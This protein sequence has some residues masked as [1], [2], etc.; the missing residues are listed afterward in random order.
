[1][2]EIVD[3]VFLAIWGIWR[4]RWT[5]IIVAWIVCLLGWFAVGSLEE[6]YT[7]SARIYV[8]S[9]NI[10]A[11][12][13]KGIAVQPNVQQRV[14]L[15]SRALLTRPNLEKLMRMA[16]LGNE[17]TNE[18]EREAIL[19]KLKYSIKLNSG[20]RGESVYT[21]SYSNTDSEVAIRVVQSLIKI[22]IDGSVGD[23][24]QE[25]FDAREFLDKQIADYEV[26]LG[27]AETRLTDFKRLNTG[28]M[29]SDS[30]GY[31]Q[32]LELSISQQRSAAL[33]LKEA[34]NR[35]DEI[36]RQME[37]ERPRIL[38]NG[39]DGSS[40]RQ[41]RIRGLQDQLDELLVRYTDRHPR[42]AQLRET[43]KELRFD[44]SQDRSSTTSANQ[45]RDL[46]SSVVYQTM[47]TMLVEAEA[48]LAELQV[49]VIDFDEQVS[50]LQGTIDSI[51]EVERRLRQ[52]DRDYE[53]VTRQ[54]QILLERRE[55]AR[56]SK[57]VVQN[58]E[59]VKFRV[60]DPPFV[61]SKPSTP[62][63]L[64]L[65]AAVLAAGLGAGAAIGLLLS[66]LRPVFYDQ[67]SLFNKTGL[68]VFGSVTLI[69]SKVNILRSWTGMFFF[70]SFLTL[71][72]LM[73]GV[74]VMM[75]LTGT[76]P[77]FLAFSEQFA[78]FAA[79]GESELLQPLANSGVIEK[80]D[81]LI[82]GS[83]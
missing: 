78:S 48:R 9:N 2:Q 61:P 81:I 49:R 72:M 35:R 12:L 1:M 3:K 20:R 30:G 17:S 71:L 42:V 57:E 74:V 13:L 40:A 66:L 33:E 21:M 62:S 77:A 6:R 83:K 7:A 45:A 24:R 75:Q 50:E 52:L 10:L 58:S 80:I 44:Q 5:G 22:F 18:K 56:L 31:F 70:A 82:Q 46:Q 23:D 67:R 15:V 69:R 26:R 38:G 36:A 28:S 60:I 32:R 19:N 53:I 79:L 43:I 54:H 8:D 65:N 14:S 41:L 51:P 27:Q 59:D 68:P 29:P 34:R 11:P 73:F 25:S 64:L 55:S 47:R 16:N 4:F 37:N 63:K 39:P 76:S